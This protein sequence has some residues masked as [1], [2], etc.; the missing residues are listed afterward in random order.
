MW[1]HAATHTRVE[2]GGGVGGATLN[3]PPNTERSS[4]VFAG[5]RTMAASGKQGS[6]TLTHSAAQRA[7]RPRGSDPRSRGNGGAAAAGWLRLLGLFA[8]LKPETVRGGS[9]QTK[10]GNKTRGGRRA[11]WPG[12]K[13]T[14][15][16]TGGA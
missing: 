11:M 15:Q 10:G 2:G 1:G 7:T 9:G 8:F 12:Q 4:S 16:R 5:C 13:V 3:Q 6:S 14:G